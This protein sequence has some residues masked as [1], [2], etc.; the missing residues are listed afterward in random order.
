M[1]RYCFQFKMDFCHE[2][3]N[4]IFNEIL[5]M[6]FTRLKFAFQ[7]EL[8]EKKRSKLILFVRFLLFFQLFFSKN[9]FH[10]SYS[11]DLSQFMQE[12]KLGSR[13]VNSLN[14]VWARK[15]N[16]AFW[17]HKAKKIFYIL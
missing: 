7:N 4:S 17:L 8:N 3:R 6:N 14:N 13:K 5:V 12:A 1:F 16:S 2:S 15:R 11:F 9:N 10:C